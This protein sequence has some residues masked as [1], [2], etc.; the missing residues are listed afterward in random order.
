[1]LV[2]GSGSVLLDAVG[3]TVGS[4]TGAASSQVLANGSLTINAPTGLS[5]LGGNQS[6][7][8]A[9]ADANGP[10]IVNV[11][12]S[13]ITI[14]AGSGA[15]AYAK[16]D[17]ASSLS[18]TA[19]SGISLQGGSGAGAYAAIIAN[20]DITLNAPSLNMTVGSGLDS[21][22]VVVSYFGRITAPSN[23]NGCV[24]LSV[25]PL[26]NGQSDFGLYEGGSIIGQSNATSVLSTQLNQ[27]NTVLQDAQRDPEEKREPQPEITV[28]GQT[29]Q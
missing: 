10:V 18:V 8:F 4:A 1:V 23:C 6:G 28:E 25:A 21:D 24:N 3:I 9:S 29:C 5:I 13:S 2:N 15:G 20:G 11:P 17:P 27:I 16:L 19:G 26:G 7:A 22:A 12:L 14:T